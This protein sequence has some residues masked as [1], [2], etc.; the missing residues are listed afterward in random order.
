MQPIPS[1]T[2]GFDGRIDQIINS[3]QQVYAHFNWKNLAADVANPFLPNDVDSEHD[4]SFLISHNYVITPSLLNEF[5]FGFTHTLFAPNFSIEGAAAIAQLG[6]QNVDVSQHPTNGGFP[7]INFSDGTGFTPIGRDIVG[8]TVSSTNQIA[9]NITYSKGKHT[10]RGG[11]DLRWVRFAVPEIET[12]SDDYG[13]F[14]FNQGVFTGNAFGDLLLGLP[15]TTYFAVGGPQDNAGAMQ[16]GLYAQDEWRVNDRL[17]LNF[18]L[19][20]ELLPPF[21]DKHGIQANFDPATNSVIINSILMANGGP[22]LGFLQG[23]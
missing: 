7:S 8:P 22:A 12:P 20:W 18:G 15:N 6:L 16:T 14:T 11:V 5:R 3:K 17:T 23:V 1:S 2:N 19:R 4:R 13:L 10:V 21:V 9:D